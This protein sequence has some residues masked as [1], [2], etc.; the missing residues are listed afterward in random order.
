MSARV[1]SRRG[2]GAAAAPEPPA[3]IPREAGNLPGSETLQS[4]VSIFI[5]KTDEDFALQGANVRFFTRRGEPLSW[6]DDLEKFRL[7]AIAVMAVS[8]LRTL[9]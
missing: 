3:P 4:L 6:L 1:A 5:D 2:S 9:R 7:S 8:D